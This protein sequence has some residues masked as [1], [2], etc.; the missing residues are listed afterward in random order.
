M[1]VGRFDT[2]RSLAA[3]AAT[4]ATET[5]TETAIGSGSGGARTGDDTPS[6]PSDATTASDALLVSGALL[7]TPDAR[8]RRRR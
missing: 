8:R 5:E 7:L 1:I 6:T 2:G 3:T 4:F